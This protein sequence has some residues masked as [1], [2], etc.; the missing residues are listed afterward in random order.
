MHK[1]LFVKYTNG[2]FVIF[3]GLPQQLDPV[4]FKVHKIKWAKT[5]DPDGSLVQ[6]YEYIDYSPQE[7]ESILT[8]YEILT[9]SKVA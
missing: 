3:K 7:L 8:Q 9:I 2:K 1:L 4:Q 6:D 5:P